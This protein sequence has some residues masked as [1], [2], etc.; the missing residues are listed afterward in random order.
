[1]PARWLTRLDIFLKGQEGLSL[2]AEPCAEWARVLDQPTRITPCKRPAPAPPLDARPER[3][4]VSDVAMLIGDPYGFYA[5]RI[6]KLSALDPLEQE[7]GAADYG[8]LIHATIHRF[9]AA[10][11]QAWPGEALARP[12]W[13]A[14]AEY[15]LAGAGLRP[16]VAALWTPRLH[17]IGEFLRGMEGQQRGGLLATWAEVKASIAVQRPGG[18][19]T[20][21]ARADRVDRCADHTLRILDYKTGTVPSKRDVEAGTAPQLP[22]EAWMAQQGGFGGIPGAAVSALEYWRLTG[23]SEPGEVKALKI[24]IPAAIAEAEA[25]LHRLADRFLLGEASFPAHPHPRRKAAM[26]YRHLARTAEWSSEA[27]GEG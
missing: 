6:L 23:A 21:E 11:P 24:D 4:T 10:L 19:I 26:D 8:N 27:E 20:L 9:L 25:A 18:T 1:V 14:A 16:A 5:R 3:V 12:L 17:R 2:P 7:P 13:N 22:L 15:A